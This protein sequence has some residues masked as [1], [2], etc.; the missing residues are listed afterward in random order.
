MFLAL[1]ASTNVSHPIL[2]LDNISIK[3]PDFASTIEGRLDQT[4]NHQHDATWL[5]FCPMFCYMAFASLHIN[6][7]G[8]LCC[9][10]W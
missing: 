8:L 1:M 9:A 3:E 10:Q 6:V 5:L 4:S 7:L 2:F